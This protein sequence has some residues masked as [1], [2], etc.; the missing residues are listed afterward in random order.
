MRKESEH[1]KDLHSGEISEETGTLGLYKRA[2]QLVV[3]RGRERKRGE[4]ENEN[5]GA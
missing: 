1:G 4:R 5:T 3:G 2:C